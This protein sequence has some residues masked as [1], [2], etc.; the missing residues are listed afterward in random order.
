MLAIDTVNVSNEMS[1]DIYLTEH[2]N[3]SHTIVL[4]KH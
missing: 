3:I 2:F 1:R 4:L